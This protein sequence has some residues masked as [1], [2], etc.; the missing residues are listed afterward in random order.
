MVRPMQGLDL[1]V[2]VRQPLQLLHLL[3]NRLH[4]LVALHDVVDVV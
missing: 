3:G 2:R 1:V 4:R